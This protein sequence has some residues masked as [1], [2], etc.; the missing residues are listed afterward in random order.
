M[1]DVVATL[2]ATIGADVTGLRRGIDEAEGRLQGLAGKI[3]GLGSGMTELGLRITGATGPL[4]TGF[5]DG[6]NRAMDFENVIAEFGARTMT[7]GTELDAVKD[8]ALEMGAV[9]AF[10]ATD[11]A[12][13]MLELVTSGSSVEEAMA[14]IGPVLDAA[15]AGGM[16][17]G[18]AADAVT[19][20]M[21]S[22]QLGVGDAAGVANILAQAASASS[23]EMPDVVAGFQNVGPAAAGFGLSVEDTA[24]A[25]AIFNDSGIKSAEAGTQLR[26]MLSNMTRDTDTVKTAWAELGTSMYDVDGNI[27]DLDTVIGE[28]GEALSGMTDEKRNQLIRDLAGEFGRMG[29]QALLAQGGLSPMLTKMGEAAD[30]SDVAA[31]RMDTLAGR[32]ESLQGSVDTLAIETLTPF[33]KDVLVPFLN[34]HIIPIV[35]GLGEWA[36]KNPAISTGLLVIGGAL[37]IAGPL[38]FGL[39]QIVMVGGTLVTGLG[40]VATGLWA[41]LGPIGV[42]AVAVAGLTLALAGL[43]N[44]TNAFKAD[45][46]TVLDY[47]KD[48]Q[49][50]LPD[51]RR[52]AELMTVGAGGEVGR[53]GPGGPASATDRRPGESADDFFRRESEGRAFGGRVSAGAYLVGERGPEL[54][55]PGESGYVAPIRMGVGGA[56]G[57]GPVAIT[58]NAYGVDD[59]ARLVDMIDTELRRRT[60]G[61]PVLRR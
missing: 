49:S 43:L 40:A 34:D 21:A 23:A 9:T 3:R 17:L 37:L 55:F 29:L 53:I 58:L 7:F 32:L 27:R 52:A 10:S 31:A 12:R 5:E 20:I 11:A 56:S 47:V 38:L 50:A 54:F 51:A 24:A 33:M 48:L 25:L 2:I 14:M 15:A 57:G 8:K 42:V 44:K 36:A 19:D 35:N 45:A 60:R 41:L 6:L 46:P 13:G 39:G 16:G 59:P 28:M 18:E 61:A 4:R 26:S 1:P 30:V 22:F